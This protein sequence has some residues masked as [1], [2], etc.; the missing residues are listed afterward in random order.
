[1]EDFI[2]TLARL[3]NWGPSFPSLIDRF[4]EGGLMDWNRSNFAGENSSLP[5]VNISENDN[6]FC[7]D[8]AAPGLKKDD[9]KVNFDNGQLTISSEKRSENEEKNG[10]KVT[11]KEFSYQ[12]FQRS[13]SI[14]ENIVSA[15]GISAKYEDGI[16][17]V[18]LPKREEAKPKPPRVISIH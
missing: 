5:A 10:E 13:F 12:S 3:N 14:P 6:E 1:M 4:F 2:M 7:I 11:R 8:V 15:E 18:V 17:H 16:L 9:F